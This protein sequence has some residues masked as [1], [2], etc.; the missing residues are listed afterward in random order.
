MTRVAPLAGDP[1]LATSACEII[2]RQ[3]LQSALPSDAADQVLAMRHRLEQ[4]VDG[5]DHLKRGWGGYVDIEFLCQFAVL[6]HSAAP[7]ATTIADTL[8]WVADNTQTN[9]KH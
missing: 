8:S 2:R 4:C 3:A 7:Y 9:D 5:R 6:T 1:A